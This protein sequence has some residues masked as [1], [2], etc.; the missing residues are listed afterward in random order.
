MHEYHKYSGNIVRSSQKRGVLMMVDPN[1]L[2]GTSW[3]YEFQEL[4]RADATLLQGRPGLQGYTKNTRPLFDRIADR[5]SP[6][7]H[8][9]WLLRQYLALKLT[10][11]ATIQFAS[12][13][14]AYEQNLQ[15]AIPYLSYYGMFNAMRANL[16]T[17]PR[18]QWG[19]STLSIGH[20]K[21]RQCYSSELKLLLAEHEVAEQAQLA[22]DAKH[23]RELMSYRFPA[24]GAP[25]K[26]GFYV[27]RDKAEQ[28]ARLAAEL[29]LFNSFCLGAAVERRF[30]Q[31]SEWPGYKGDVES[32]NAAWKHKLK[33][34]ADEPDAV[35][36]DAEDLYRVRQMARRVKSPVPFIWLTGEGAVEDFFGSFISTVDSEDAF[37]PDE[38]WDRLLS[39]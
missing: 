1:A 18:Y 24:S 22:V 30:G 3:A 23:G 13:D 39:L 35:Y 14:H 15:I 17:S 29:A 6:E 28:F 25:G 34:S 20:D 36:P 10:M 33:A 9:E 7:L 32:F 27:Q 11:A 26:G 31:S 8:T 21:A 2:A 38:H 5:W 16:L 19:K 37:N 4:Q 12:A